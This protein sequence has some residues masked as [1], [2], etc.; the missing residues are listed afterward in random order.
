MEF[1]VQKQEQ[2]MLVY[3]EHNACG[4]QE[5]NFDT[6]KDNNDCETQKP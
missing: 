2:H 3:W 1:K 6:K 4:V 5:N